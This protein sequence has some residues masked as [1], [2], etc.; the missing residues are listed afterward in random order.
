ML[1]IHL[2]LGLP[3]GLFPSGF[4]TNNLYTLI[5]HNYET[6]NKIVFKDTGYVC[7]SDGHHQVLYNLI[8]AQLVKKIPPPPFTPHNFHYRLDK[9]RRLDPWATEDSVRERRGEDRQQA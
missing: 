1:S 2:R 8:V 4:P 7:G 6:I 9:S 3:S 5:T